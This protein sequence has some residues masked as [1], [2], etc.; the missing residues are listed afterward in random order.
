MCGLTVRE[1]FV[2]LAAPSNDAL[3]APQA[4]LP[5][6]IEASSAYGQVVADRRGRTSAYGQVPRVL[7]FEIWGLGVGNGRT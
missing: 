5:I 6:D 2:G 7:G 3:D 4:N 1:E